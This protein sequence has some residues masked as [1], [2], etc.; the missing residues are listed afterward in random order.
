M[1]MSSLCKQF[2]FLPLRNQRRGLRHHLGSEKVRGFFLWVFFFFTHPKLITATN[3]S[4]CSQEFL[5]LVACSYPTKS[6]NLLK[7]SIHVWLEFWVICVSSHYTYYLN[8]LHSPLTF[9]FSHWSNCV[10]QMGN[11]I[12]LHHPWFAKPMCW[13]NSI[14]HKR[15]EHAVSLF[16]VAD[17]MVTMSF[18]WGIVFKRCVLFLR[19]LL[20]HIQTVCT[21]SF[22]LINST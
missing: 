19:K 15:R 3:P 20:F 6:I 12:R 9:C 21:A 2:F 14:W 1:V 4:L 22:Q 7:L 18:S 16:Q 13:C 17:Y 8:T 11:L 10:K 5:L